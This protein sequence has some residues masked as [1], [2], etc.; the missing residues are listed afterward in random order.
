MARLITDF[1]WSTTALGDIDGWSSTVRTSIEIMLESRHPIMTWWGPEFTFLYNDAFAAP[2]GAK[3]PAALGQP[4]RLVWAEI[5]PTI[6][7]MLEGVL[8]NG[9]GTWSDDLLL[10]I[11]RRGFKEDTYWTF[12]YSPIR[13]A[14]G[15]VIGVFAPANELTSR[16]LG[17]RRLALLTRLAEIS[18]DARL[19]DD[20]LAASARV[21]AGYPLEVPFG[22]LYRCEGGGPRLVAS[23]GVA[24]LTTDLPADLTTDLTEPPGAP[25]K[26]EL[27][28]RPLPDGLVTDR[29]PAPR[30]M[31]TTVLRAPGGGR[32]VG[33]VMLGVYPRI[34]LDE[35]YVAF[36]RMIAEHI[37]TA[38]NAARA[39]E[40]EQDR[41]TALAE[42]DQAKS[43]FFSNISHEFRTPLTLISEPAEECL[44][45]Q[46]QPLPAAHRDR[47]KMVARN[48]RR[49]HRMVNNVLDFTSLEA[50][51][52]R[53][54]ITAI[55]IA[56]TTRGLAE[57]FEFAMRRAG[58]QLVIDVPPIA[59]PVF[60][61][62]D[63]WER[64]TLN[65]LS[66]ALKYTLRGTVRVSLRAHDEH[67][68]LSVADTGVG[69]VA[70]EIPLVFRRFH[71][72]QSSGGRSQEGTGIGLAMVH[73]LVRLHHGSIEVSSTPGVGSTFTVSLPFGAGNAQAEAPPRV[74][75]V[76]GYLEEA[77]QWIGSSTDQRLPSVQPAMDVGSTGGATVLVVEDNPDMR[78]FLAQTL[79]AYWQV[80]VAGDGR[81]AL[82]RVEAHPPD[83][84][85]TDV[86][87]PG[88][89][90]FGLLRALRAGRRTATT[91]VVLLSARAGEEAAVEGLDAGADDYLAKPFSSQ[92]LI[93]R[94]RANLELARLRNREAAWRTAL[95]GSI[96]DGLMV[97]DG[98]GS[99]VEVN[100]AF[101]S[102]LGYGPAD[103]PY[104]RPH[105]WLP[106]FPEES[107]EWRAVTEAVDGS[108]AGDGLRVTVPLRHRDGRQVWVALAVSP[109]AGHIHYRLA[110]CTVRDVTADVFAAQRQAALAR[111][112]GHLAPAVGVR[113]VLTVG[114][115][116]LSDELAASAA[117]AVGWSE[118]G[119]PLVLAA[120]AGAHPDTARR[121]AL[122]DRAATGGER[123][124]AR[125]RL[126]RDQRGQVTG[127]VAEVGSPIRPYT[128]WLR[129]QHPVT[130]E[131]QARVGLLCDALSQALDRAEVFDMQ[132]TVALTLQRAML[133]PVD[134]PVGCA[135]R[136][137]PAV[138]PLEVG[139]DWYDVVE[140][141]NGNL[142]LVVGD[143][144]GRGLGAAAVMGQV[145]SAC[146]ALILQEKAPSQVL[147]AL[148]AFAWQLP[149]ARCTTVFCAVVDP[150]CGLLR[151]S[152]AGHPPGIVV[153][154]DGGHEL[155]THATSVPLA[156]AP[157]G[158]RPE[159]TAALDTGT[160]LVLYT[161]GL[162]ERRT[163]SM[164]VAIQR[165]LDTVVAQRALTPERLVSQVVEAFGAEPGPDDVAVLAYQRMTGDRPM[166]EA[167]VEASPTELAPL[168]RSL[169]EWLG[170]NRMPVDVVNAV[171]LATSEAC[172]NAMEHG[173]RLDARQTVFITATIGQDAVTMIVADTGSWLEPDRARD[174]AQNRG[175]GIMI[176]KGVM[177]KIIIDGDARG[178]TVHLTKRIT[179]VP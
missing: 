18:V 179:H 168:R 32:P 161:D 131:D 66:N 76:G 31:A 89:D 153:H 55:D 25:G 68:A 17:E 48:A 16:V 28:I 128:I 65:L 22:L 92:E 115:T 24:D 42:L 163:E 9:L 30:R 75:A 133:G 35:E 74:S 51:R 63:M 165:A 81:E 36:L 114:V 47:L 88:L 61:D 116:D 136:Y 39:A 150:G 158:D 2:S 107:A 147:Q 21:L 59:R 118:A 97:I 94:V 166:L 121:A 8:A 11:D 122:R 83:L 23:A 50:G 105:P 164:H 177:D 172:A 104:Q 62:P 34:V 86:M 112:T 132:H 148:D 52:V 151:Y 156:T 101:G 110:V 120:T 139:G 91:A 100:D 108:V 13:E 85:L 169:R 145:R 56:A 67:I 43:A 12:S 174:V 142:G 130:D 4:G 29:R 125:L 173:S 178:T 138:R 102:I 159:S 149:G 141:A 20:V 73:E 45:D 176:M 103:V 58:L 71:R 10:V 60:A 84:V 111:L 146:R 38:V 175:R 44:A 160:F 155:L 152:S 72:A 106:D 109:V 3:H 77:L 41:I 70:S 143:C 78:R 53:T 14:D 90:G 126:E 57:S 46:A 5:W 157:V 33:S 54:R 117:A 99:V 1:D 129:V 27:A 144:V 26:A 82:E 137:Q 19:V 69:I 154:P 87:M 6:G 134:L 119:N 124:P 95:I 79:S 80:S 162:V 113:E 15:R 170:R 96:Q 171:V 127:V 40:E 140:L 135:A 98:A 7:P 64:I 93:A 167:T 123:P 37:E 49:L